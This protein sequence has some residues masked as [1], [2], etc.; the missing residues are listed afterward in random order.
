ME[1]TNVNKT[2]CRACGKPIEPLNSG[3]TREII[4]SHN[5]DRN[6][7]YR[8]YLD[9][10]M[11]RQDKHIKCRVRLAKYS[12]VGIRLRWLLP[13][14]FIVNNNNQ[15]A[16]D[17]VEKVKKMEYEELRGSGVYFYGQPGTGKTHLLTNL[18]CGLI[19]NGYNHRNVIWANTSSLLTK[20]RSSFSKKYGYGEETEQEIALKKLQTKFLFLD[21]I[22]TE[23]ATDWAKE[24]LYD[25]IN[26]RYEERLPTFI[27]SNLSPQELANRLG[28]K[29]ASRVI[30]MCKPIRVEGNDWRLKNADS[31][32]LTIDNPQIEMP[33]F[34]YDMAS[35]ENESRYKE[36]TKTV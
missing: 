25:V 4:A 11:F 13:D 6:D 18:C 35:W 31:R 27:S 16:Y 32:E 17:Y 22:G 9:L 26:Y 5:R 20:I 23:S 14:K 30:E 28:D 34:S 15:N 2:I 19:D 36:F 21:D 29:F 8:N 7:P 3:L 12:Y 10:G 24:I 33:V 1:N